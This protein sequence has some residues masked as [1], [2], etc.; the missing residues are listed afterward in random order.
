MD[1]P[2]WKL[3]F[4]LGLGDFYQYGLF[5]GDHVRGSRLVVEKRELPK[6]ISS[7]EVGQRSNH[8]VIAAANHKPSG[9][10]FI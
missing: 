5:S 9:D 4:E 2:K 10:D 7:A 1:Q 8:A 6:V 3:L